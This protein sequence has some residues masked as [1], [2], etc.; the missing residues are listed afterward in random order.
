M[1]LV[2]GGVYQGKLAYALKRFGLTEGDVHFCNEE[3][4]AVPMGKR[5]VNE[6]DRWILAL[7]RADMDVE[8]KIGQFVENNRDAIVICSDISCGVVPV[9][10][11]LRNW[12]EAVGRS[13]G[14]L[15]QD[16][17]EVIRLFCGIPTRLK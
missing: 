15:A 5:I 17:G 2:F 9:D 1:I 13:L 12:R 6:I 8:E 4:T 16:S 7:V 10:S 14:L 3:D 11:I